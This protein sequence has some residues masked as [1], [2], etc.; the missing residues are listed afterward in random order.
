MLFTCLI[1]VGVSILSSMVGQLNVQARFRVDDDTWP[2]DQPKNFVPLVLIHYEG[3]RNL[4]QAMAITKLTQTG[5]LALL[6]ND[7]PVSKCHPS[8]QPLQKVREASTVTKEVEQIL[9]PLEKTNKPQFILVEGPPGIGKSVL[10]KEIA[11][12]WGD[13]QIL[14]DFKFV[15]LLCLRDPIVQQTESVYDLLQLFCVGHRRAPEIT[16]ACNDYIFENGGK[17]L[18][19]L[20][21]G[22]DEI[23]TELQNNSLISKILERRVLPMCGLIVSSRPHASENLRKQATLRVDILGFTETERVSFIQ[24][25]LPHAAKELTEYL[26]SN[27]TINGLCFVPFN[28]VVLVYLYKQGISFPSN[29]TELYN[30]FICLTICRHLAK[31]G[32]PLDSPIELATL[33]KPYNT[34]VEQLSKMSFEGLNNNQLIFTF[35]EVRAACPDITAI[36]GALTGF[37]LLQTIQHFGLTGK[38]MTFNFIHFSI[39][40]FLAAYH[41][42]QLP[43]QEELQVLKAKFWSNLHSNMFAMYTS[44]TKGQ[45]S[46]FKQFLCGGDSI[47]NISQTFLKDQIKCLRLYHCFHEANDEVFYTS[48]QNS[49]I[50]DDKVINLRLTSLSP[51]DVECVTLF[52]TYSHEKQWRLLNLYW[53]DI[54]DR[55]LCVLHRDL[56]RSDISLRVLVLYGNGLTRSSASSISDLTIHCSVEELAIGDNYT[57]GE[58]PA[59]YN[60]VSHPSSMLVRLYMENVSLSATSAIVLFTAVAKGNKLQLLYISNNNIT[61][62]TC[63]VIAASLSKNSSLGLLRM[64]DNKISAKGAQR[65]V[66]ALHQNSTLEELWLSRY[67]E[68]VNRINFLQEEIIKNRE[69]RGCRTKLNIYCK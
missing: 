41:I 53:C 14:K 23:P 31:S 58:D 64:R 52:L 61:D 36:P 13:K 30:H 43:P 45:R 9:V 4:Q 56:M 22:F 12:R 35:K 47:V 29:S 38:T 17:D 1:S 68:V 44:L 59:L 15:L 27:L 42:T 39:Q 54:Q 65:I 62:D 16:D 18:V 28:M 69:S 6:A 49:Q 21:D 67:P 20:L 11:Y 66:E 60:M 57:I 26:D 33:P 7:Q 34:V 48:I 8:H 2:P 5:D 55:G 63:E 3:H 46:A 37:G 19:F 24:Q 25:A 10:L 51:Y 32:H 40:E 50:F